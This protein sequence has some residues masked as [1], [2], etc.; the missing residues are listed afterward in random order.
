MYETILALTM[1]AA[2]VLY[3]LFAGADFGGGMWDMLAFGPNRRKQREAIADAIGPVWEANH[4]WL[5]LAIVLLFSAFPPAFGIVMT[6]LFV[7]MVVVLIGIVIRGATFVFRKYDVQRDD[8]HERWSTLF[9]VASFL[10]PF[11]LGL[12]LGALGSGEIRV[13]DGVLVSGFTAGWTDPFAIGCGLFAQGLFAYLAA[14]YMTVET[15]GQPEVQWDFRA[16]ALV[17]GLTLL[18]AALLVYLLAVD[19]APYLFDRLTEWWS[20]MLWVA[21][22]LCAV[23]ALGSLVTRRYAWARV[24]AM[25]QVTLILVGWALAQ[26]PYVVVPDV[27]FSDVATAPATLRL[28]TWILAAGTVLLVPAFAYLFLIFKRT[29]AV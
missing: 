17:S 9:G 19:G 24:A 28:L 26:Y 8:V 18:P 13:E 10:T 14:V 21:T 3:G 20:P 29:K 16:R 4:V 15:A 6:A 22:S 11:F 27:T 23:A 5:I 2:I 7:P 1:L 12:S 25:L